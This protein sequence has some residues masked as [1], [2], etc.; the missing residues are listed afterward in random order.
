MALAVVRFARRVGVLGIGLEP[1]EYVALPGDR[2]NW[3]AVRCPGCKKVTMTPRRT[4]HVDVWGNVSP[5]VICPSE[6]CE[7]EVSVYRFEDW[8]PEAKG[9]A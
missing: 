4:F 1:G 6:G 3:A 7:N 5:A 2:V 9:L 8:V